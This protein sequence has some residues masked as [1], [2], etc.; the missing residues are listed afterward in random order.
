[1]ESN[2]WLCRESLKN[3]TMC[4]GVWSKYFL[5]SDRCAP[6]LPLPPLILLAHLGCAME[7][8]ALPGMWVPNQ[9]GCQGVPARE[10]HLH[11]PAGSQG[12]HTWQR[13]KALTQTLCIT[14]TSSA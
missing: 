11:Q 1:M 9:Q 10:W 3:H 13:L 7:G 2:S 6:H 8:T 14:Q 12:G 4:L 5:N